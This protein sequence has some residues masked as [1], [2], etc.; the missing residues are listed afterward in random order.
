MDRWSVG[1]GV[2]G[3]GKTAEAADKDELLG[4]DPRA[5][6][7]TSRTCCCQRWER[8]MCWYQKGLSSAVCSADCAAA[9]DV[10]H[11]LWVAQH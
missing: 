6:T 3:D 4:L 1:V 5:G 8:Y 2:G 9:P 11:S 7:C 10:P